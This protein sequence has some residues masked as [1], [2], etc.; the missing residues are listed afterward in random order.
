MRRRGE[1]TGRGGSTSSSRVSRTRS[2]SATSG[3]SPT[4]ATA[5]AA[6]RTDLTATSFHPLSGGVLRF[7]RIAPNRLFPDFA[8]VLTI[9]FYSKNNY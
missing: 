9:S 1:E 8:A 4:S 3:A 7:H 2:D 6:V 5:T